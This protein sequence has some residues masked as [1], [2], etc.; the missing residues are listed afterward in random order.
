MTTAVRFEWTKLTTLRSTGWTLLVAGALGIGFA[1]LFGNGG[2]QGYLN[3][4]P[5]EQAAFDPT[6]VSLRSHLFTQL[7]VAVLGVLTVTGE[8]ATGTVHSSLAAVPRRH[9]L[10]AA[11]AGVVGA[12]GL[13]VGEVVALAS[14]LIGQAV[15]AGRVPS[16]ALD[17]P[18]VP[19]AVLGCGL[20]LALVGVA[21]VAV[22]VLVRST[23]G[24]VTA[25]L[26]ATLL[27]P[28]F[29]PHPADRTGPA[30]GTVLADPGRRSDHDRAAGPGRA[31]TVGRAGGH[32]GLGGG[33]AGRGVRRAP[34]AGRLRWVASPRSWS[35]TT[36]P[37]CAS[38][39]RRR[40]GSS[41][42]G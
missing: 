39:S 31:P 42:S 14:F 34:A 20:Y 27:V 4:T 28:A 12:V 17:Q 29:H 32:G 7:A 16:A 5:D 25:M 30:G 23:A 6:A 24:A 1:V 13:V 3:G 22:G 35:W 38:C 8:Y 21:G 18:G 33:A 36:S 2:V 9:R 15:M 26:S 11:K 10:L 41:A 37:A 40:C 19:R